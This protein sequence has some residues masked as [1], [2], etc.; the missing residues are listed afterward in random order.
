MATVL[1]DAAD[2]YE[3]EKIEWC[4]N[5]WLLHSAPG[6]GPRHQLTVC[7]ATALGLAAGLGALVPEYLETHPGSRPEPEDLRGRWGWAYVWTEEGIQRYRAARACVEKRLD[8]DLTG[9]NDRI[10]AVSHDR[11]KLRHVPG[12]TK[13][14]I[15][16][17]FKD[18]AEE[19]RN[20]Q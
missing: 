15:I 6:M 10:D 12:C 7:A 2:A 14:D 5:K 19:L 16:D 3:S 8:L 13:Q 17:L 4:Q 20:G 9:F 18:T 1:E 11:H